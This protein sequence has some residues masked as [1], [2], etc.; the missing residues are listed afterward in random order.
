MSSSISAFLKKLYV[1]GVYYT[2]VSMVNPKG[3]YQL[4][5][6]T[7]EEF[8]KLYNEAL[9]KDGDNFIIGLAEKPQNYMPVLCDIDIKKTEEEM[10][11][12]EII[13]NHI[14]TEKNLNDV[15]EIYQSVLRNIIDDCADDHLL[16]VV[17]EKNMYTLVKNGLKIYKH[18]FHL[19]FPNCF[20]SKSEQ[21][22]HL[23][24]R[25]QNAL[26]DLNVFSNLDYEDSSCVLDA[27]YLKSPWLLYGGRKEGE[28]MRP[29]KITKIINSEGE[30]I[31]AD[32]A[33]KYY[34]VYNVSDQLVDIKDNITKNLPRI[35]SILP[36]GRSCC[37]IKYGLPSPI[38]EKFIT[39]HKM[40]DNDDNETFKDN[41]SLVEKLSISKKLLSML[42]DHRA[43]DRNEWMTIGWILYNIGDGCSEALQ[44]WIDFSS[45]SDDKFDENECVNHWQKMTKK[46]LSIGSLHYFAKMDN[47]EM[48]KEFQIERGR[49]HIEEG[50][51]GSHND[52]AKLMHVL[53]GTEYVCASITNKTWY[54]FKNHHWEEI[55]GGIFLR[56]KISNEIVKTFGKHGG[57]VFYK[58]ALVDSTEEK[59]YQMR[60]K[61]LSKLISNLKNSPYKSN[62]MN[63]A[64][65]VFFNRNFKEKLDI[66]P[67]LIGFKN[68]VY[69]LKL[70]IFRAGRPEDYIS[71]CMPINYVNFSKTDK[72]VMDVYDYLEKVF[73]DT[74]VRNYFLDTSS[75]VFEGGNKQKTII[76]WTGEGDNAKSVTQTIL[77]RMLGQY[78]IKFNTTLVT[79]KKVQTGSSNPELARAGGGVRW[80][81][82]EE[83]DGDEELNVGMLKSLSGND[84]YWA[85]DLFE[86]GKSTREITPLFK[87]IFI[88][89]AGNTAVSL[90]NGISVSL[91]KLVH[92]KNQKLLSW[93]S[94]KDGLIKT[95]QHAFIKKGLQNCITLTLQDGR[96]IT[97]TPNHK[98]LTDKNEWV[99]AQNIKIKDTF[100]KMGLDN[101][102]CDDIFDN[103]DYIL[104]CGKYSF[105]CKD[106][107]NRLQAMAYVR[108]LGYMLSDGSCNKLLYPGHQIDGQ[109]I[110]DDIKLLT[111]KIPKLFKNKKVFQ[112][113]L[114]NEL[115]RSISTIIAYQKGGRINND[116]ILPDFVFDNNCPNFIIREFIA[117]LFGGDGIIPCLSKNYFTNIQLVAS[118][119]NEKL[120]TL[121]DIFNKL[122][123]LLKDRFDI[124]SNI[125]TIPYENEPKTYV[126]LNI[127][128]N[129]SKIKFCENIG[130]RFCC[131][132][133]Y[134]LMSVASYYRYKNFIIEQNQNIIR[135]TKELYDKYNLQNPKPLIIQKDKNTFKIL[136]TFKSTQEVENTLGIY[137]SSIRSACLRNGSS[138]GYLWEYK[139]VKSL[140]Q[141]ESGCETIKNSYLQAVNEITSKTGIINKKYII[142]YTQTFYYLNNNITYDMPSIDIKEFL[143]QNDL[144]QFMNQGLGKTVKHYSVE[145]ERDSLPCYKM[146]I[147][148]IENS[149]MKEVF[150]IN[151]DE[152][153]SNFLAEGILT[154]NCNKLI[155]IKHADKAFW[156]RVKVLP[157]ETTFVRPGQP[158]PST[159]EEQLQQKKFPMDPEFNKKIPGLLEPFCWLL[160]EHR[161]SI[162]GKGRVEPEKVKMATNMYRKQNDIYRQFLDECVVKADK[163][164]SLTELYEGFLSWYRLGYPKH[165]VPIRNDVQEY[166]TKLWDEPEKGMRWYGYRIKTLDEEIENGDIIIL[167]E[168]DIVEYDKKPNKCAAPV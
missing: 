38:K 42:S 85:R 117:A 43:D 166:F 130:V 163:Y 100:L 73:P 2:H 127:N 159:Y 34:N 64:C 20:L 79:G 10:E 52:I 126:F 150:D 138:G 32:E 134:R 5:R 18:G 33:F 91:E 162:Q 157:F 132:K 77:E 167:G 81:V 45:R 153:Y 83:P 101:P 9:V 56:E 13:D 124:E 125:T 120:S 86:K 26:K 140:D 44:Q 23:I 135:R 136:N 95:Q 27:G 161:K 35:L 3:K 50:I 29:Y 149:G 67:Y 107:D 109:S 49:K 97:C 61:Q 96:K 158:C 114:P 12:I 48:Y 98:F 72:R 41:D 59:V 146:Q 115:V 19:H 110:L 24:P 71:K 6:D 60:I 151:V 99:E 122:S 7:F 4:N 40:V 116:M 58:S 36:S 154:H 78:A 142:N 74:S 84:S 137:H 88:C 14:Y 118:K 108:L 53:Y 144:T 139:N 65:E 69:D 143:E 145:K 104:E 16:C 51:E 17:L 105:N 76:F 168:N 31:S 21:E 8:W 25:V 39:K 46:D 63:E 111:N 87:L 80:A 113:S 103:Y 164:I 148:N 94:E 22:N 75:D 112:T 57:E 28:N 54:Q 106:Y 128:K 37:E 30:N 11:T 15:V 156:N 1:E 90:A 121:L 47:E 152:P 82:L 119:I 147:I 133:S 123:I 165:S 92:N 102:K 89:L 93:D 131:H 68:G 55:E 129:E 66:N 155:K 160:L 141:D 62:I 70:N